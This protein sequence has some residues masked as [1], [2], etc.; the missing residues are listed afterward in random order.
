MSRSAAD[1]GSTD[2]PRRT[3]TWYGAPAHLRAEPGGLCEAGLWGVA[4]PHP[5][6]VNWFIRHGLPA[7]ARLRLAYWHELGHLQALPIV[8]AA[9]LLTT[10]SARQRGWRYRALAFLGLNGLWEW[11]AESYVVLKTGRDYLRIYRQTPNVF[12]I[13]FWVSMGALSLTMFWCCLS[14]ISQTKE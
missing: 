8:V 11:L 14:L 1:L 9:A 6:V 7:D 12:L 2:L 4:L 10:R 5:S 13:P 3:R